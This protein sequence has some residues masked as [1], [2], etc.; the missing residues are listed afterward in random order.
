MKVQFID[1]RGDFFGLLAEK[2]GPQFAFVS[3]DCAPEVAR[4]CDAIIFGLAAPAHPDHAEQTRS[5]RQLVSRR[6]GPPVI[7]M[8][9]GPDRQLMRAAI[10]AGAYDYVLE[11]APLDEL[12]LVLNRAARF[13]ELS[14]EVDRLR[15]EA[16]VTVMEEIIG[17]DDKLRAL[18]TAARRAAPTSAT[19]L[20]TGESGTGKELLARAI[21]RLSANAGG[22]FVAVAC[23]SLPEAL[24]TPRSA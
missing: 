22:P 11:N 5:L 20:I 17:S 8:L 6:G 12:I 19:V 9:G 24:T 2:L 13:Y 4:Q 7:A 10:S 16:P 21:H 15:S 1:D 23:S 3:G 18:F 14:R